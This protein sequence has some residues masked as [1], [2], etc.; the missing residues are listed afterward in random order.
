MAKRDGGWKVEV[1]ASG[2]SAPN[3]VEI[4]GM[5][6]ELTDRTARSLLQTAGSS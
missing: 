4:E 5:R 3:G 2:Y 1:C 6:K